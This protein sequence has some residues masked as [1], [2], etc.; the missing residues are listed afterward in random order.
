VAKAFYKLKLRDRLIV[1]HSKIG[2]LR[3]VLRALADEDML[4]RLAQVKFKKRRI[5]ARD[6]Q[7]LNPDRPDL[8]MKEA[9][10]IV[11]GWWLYKNAS[12]NHIVSCLAHICRVTGLAYGDDLRL[13]SDNWKNRQLTLQEVL[14]LF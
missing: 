8:V 13:V 10:R 4:A 7:D 1:D 11:D 14:D 2:C 6:P 5:V 3:Q 12:E 9:E